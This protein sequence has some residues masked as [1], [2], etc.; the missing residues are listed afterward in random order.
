MAR[1]S[2][3]WRSP[4]ATGATSCAA[5]SPPRSPRR[6]RSRCSSS[7]TAPPTARRRWCATSSRACAWSASM[8]S[9]GLIARRN[10]LASLARAPIL[11][12]LDDD[13]EF[14]AP[15]VVAHALRPFA[16]PRVGAVAIPYVEVGPWRDGGPPARSRAGR[17]V[18]DRAV[19]R[20]R[21]RA[22]DLGLPGRSAATARR[23]CATPRSSTTGRACSARASSPASAGGR[24]STTTS[25]PGGSSPTSSTSTAA[26]TSCTRGA[27]SPGPT[28]SGRALKVAAVRR[29][30]RPPDGTSA[31]GGARAGRLAVA[32][33]VRAPRERR[34]VSRGAYRLGRRI[35]FRGPLALD[36]PPLARASGAPPAGARPAAPAG[37][38][39]PPA[40]PPRTRP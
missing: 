17:A 2:P 37:R 16:D 11:V 38:P 23:W 10:D 27:T 28:R 18:R 20:D 4:P 39:A 33:V 8:S 25:R 12:S 36:A 30:R 9:A 13:A 29:R 6:A 3:R 19:H 31:G 15:D 35:R 21:P 22:A 7:T 26:T 40:A 1:R 34:P 32:G 24:R 14:T 5:R